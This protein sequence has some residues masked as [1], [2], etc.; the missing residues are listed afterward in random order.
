[1]PEE[2]LTFESMKHVLSEPPEVRKEAENEKREQ[3]SNTFRTATF[4]ELTKRTQP[5]VQSNSN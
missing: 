2:E 4:T 3:I 1:M 5:K